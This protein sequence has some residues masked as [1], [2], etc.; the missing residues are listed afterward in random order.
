[1]KDPQSRNNPPEVEDGPEAGVTVRFE[2]GSSATGDVLVGADGAN[3]RVRAQL[4][5]HAQRIETG[6]LAVSGKLSLNDR[7]RAMTPPAVFRGPTLVVGPKG[8]FLFANAVEYA[9]TKA[10][11]SNTQ[12]SVNSADSS[13]PFANREEYVMWGFSAHREKFG[14]TRRHETVSPE[15]LKNRSD[16][17]DKGLESCSSTN[18][19]ADIRSQYVHGQNFSP[20]SSVGNKKCDTAGGRSA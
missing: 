17:V 1:M 7:V 13:L 12:D 2:D 11:V 18:R 15:D 8:C 5:P 6:I 10:K 16:G 9:D 14:L 4:L 19:S 3:S 20:D